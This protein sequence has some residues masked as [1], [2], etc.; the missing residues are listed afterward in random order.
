MKGLEKLTS[1]RLAEALTQK[2]VVPNEVITDALYQ[3]RHGESFV[4]ILVSSGGITEW[5]L[6]KLVVEHFQ[7]PF[8][9]AGSY[10]VS[11]EVRES[12]PKEELFKHHIVP[13]DRFGNVLTIAMP[14]LTP[15]EQL[16]QVAKASGCNLYPYVGLI[17][18]NRKVLGTMF[19]DFFDWQKTEEERRERELAE[20]SKKRTEATKAEPDSWTD[21]FDLGDAE[22]RHSLGDG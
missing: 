16:A 1:I 5:D 7:I 13:L 9:M 12:V 2:G 11:D 4:E 15:Y 6:A 3:G 10:E 21:I 17:T 20:R 18:E 19:P 22:V 8:L 14:V